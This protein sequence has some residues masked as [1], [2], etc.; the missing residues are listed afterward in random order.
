MKVE[1]ETTP[2]NMI[3][4]I[5][6]NERLVLAGYSNRGPGPLD[7]DEETIE[8]VKERCVKKF[9]EDLGTRYFESLIATF[10]ERHKELFPEIFG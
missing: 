7:Y 3:Q 2:E 4:W 1:G 8:A 10:P 9:G 5:A 6:D